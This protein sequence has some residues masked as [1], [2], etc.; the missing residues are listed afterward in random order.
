MLVAEYSVTVFI[1][2]CYH[3][4]M[5]RYLSIGISDSRERMCVQE[6]ISGNYSVVE[7]LWLERL[8]AAQ[9]RPCTI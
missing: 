4:E 7:V 6:S 5:S 8:E 1:P 3:V 2:L 9:P